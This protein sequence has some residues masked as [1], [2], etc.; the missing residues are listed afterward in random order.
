MEYNI[1]K[2]TITYFYSDNLRKG[3]F[4]RVTLK[5]AEVKKLFHVT[6]CN[7]IEKVVNVLQWDSCIYLQPDLSSNERRLQIEFIFCLLEP[8]CNAAILLYFRHV[9]FCESLLLIRG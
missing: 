8:N 3:I 6:E 7:S 2:S 9:E 5:L 1:F 4:G